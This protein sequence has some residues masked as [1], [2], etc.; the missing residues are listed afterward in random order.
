MHKF[1]GIQQI[2][3]QSSLKYHLRRYKLFF[4]TNIR[5]SIC[6]FP[7]RDTF[8]FSSV[9][10]YNSI[11][12]NSFYKELPNI[13]EYDPIYVNKFFEI[14]FSRKS[15]ESVKNLCLRRERIS[16]LMSGRINQFLKRSYLNDH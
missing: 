11:L 13:I 4:I 15:I 7:H 10:T 8:I 14:M 9:I 1:L 6:Y 5:T 3:F 2:L 12:N 16:K